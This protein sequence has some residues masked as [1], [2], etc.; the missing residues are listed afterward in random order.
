MRKIKEEITSIF[1]VK[2]LGQMKLFCLTSYVK[3]AQNKKSILLISF[4]MKYE[5]MFYNKKNNEVMTVPSK[6]GFFWKM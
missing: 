6:F 4:K 3:L 2:G 5:R 1:M